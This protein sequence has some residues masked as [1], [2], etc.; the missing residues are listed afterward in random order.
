ML[1]PTRHSATPFGG[2]TR[3]GSN[4]TR[5]AGVSGSRRLRLATATAFAALAVTAMTACGSDNSQD[6]TPTS[7]TTATS[8]SAAATSAAA[9]PAPT[10][11]ELQATL[12]GFVDPAKPTAEKEKLVV[13]GDKRAANIDTMTTGLANY[14]TITFTVADIKTEGDQATGQV[15]ITSPHGPAG[16][17]PMTW[18]HSA[19]GWQLSDASACQILAM[20]MAPCQ[21]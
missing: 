13:G 5:T 20:G 4:A 10:A 21:P 12:N 2:S 9:A 6:S 14:G 1:L 15:T 16:P 17:M 7:T 19:A 3:T 11:E 8:A 18:Q